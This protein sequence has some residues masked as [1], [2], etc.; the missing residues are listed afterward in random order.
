MELHARVAGDGPPLVLL[1]GLFG[2]NENLGAV[3][4][5]LSGRFTIYGFDLRNHGRS[6]HGRRMD[7]ATLAAD[8]RETMDAHALDHAAVL[9][10]SLGG[11]TAMELALSSPERVDRLVIVDIAPVAYDRR[12]DRELEAM[13]AL[14]VEGLGSRGEAD[15]ALKPHVPNPAIRQFLLKNLVRGR[16]G[17]EWRIPLDTIRAAYPEI[18]AAP[19][20]AGPYEGPALFVRGGNSDYVPDDAEPLIRER[21]PNAQIETVPGA[22]HW[23][24]I[25]A[26][27]PFLERLHIFLTCSVSA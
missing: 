8:V 12:H 13:C 4:R 9:G 14:D 27:G 16:E 21:F 23:V 20:A 7:Y 22:A 10:H 25:D 18:A 24:H 15:G 1:H 5:A 26:T 19:A 2:S 11:K 3:A 17:F 6:P